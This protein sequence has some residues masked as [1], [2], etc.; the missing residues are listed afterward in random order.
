MHL[1]R[2][3]ILLCTLMIGV[4]VSLSGQQ[5]RWKELLVRSIQLS[6][7]G[8]YA[9]AIP[10]AKDA[11]HVAEATFGPADTNV[12]T[13]LHLLAQLY[14]NTRNKDKYSEAESLL[15]RAL[16]IREKALGPEHPDVADILNELGNLYYEEGRYSDAEPLLKRALDVYEKALGPEHPYVAASSNNLGKL[17]RDVGN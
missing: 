13:S 1:N 5:E 16:D 10:L 7:E 11:L 8:K 9:E 17:Y 3:K 2:R 12:A 14:R 15:K 6:N 4:P